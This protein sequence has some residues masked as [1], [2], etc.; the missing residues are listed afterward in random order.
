MFKD[1]GWIAFTAFLRAGHKYYDYSDAAFHSEC[2][3]IWKD[4][5][6][7]QALYDRFREI[8]NERPRNAP[9]QEAMEWGRHAFDELDL[10]PK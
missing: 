5:A 4:N 6:E 7:F 1:Q 10:G 9:W 2:F 8:W 3:M